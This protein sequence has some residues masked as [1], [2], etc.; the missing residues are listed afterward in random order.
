MKRRNFLI[1]SATTVSAAAVGG[2]LSVLDD[3][4]EYIGALLRE[5][6]GDFTM[7]AEQQRQFVEA[8]SNHYGNDKVM[9]FVGLHRIRRS[10]SLGTAYTHTKMDLYE[11]RL[12][13][14]FM[15]STDFFGQYQEGATPHVNFTGFKQPCSNP[16][17]RQVQ[18]A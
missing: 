4:Y 10:T 3:P 18:T 12:I 1:L 9:V 7:D 14:D 15:T 13:S 16:F 5:F 11:R 17:A 6:V 2:T 8:F